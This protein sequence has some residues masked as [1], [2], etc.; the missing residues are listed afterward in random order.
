MKEILTNTRAL[1]ELINNSYNGSIR[2]AAKDIG[3]SSSGL[4]RILNEERQIS[5]ESLKKL[6][7]YCN[8]NGLSINDYIFLN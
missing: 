6:N 4:W 2:K 5:G 8:K 3:L 1:K 7:A